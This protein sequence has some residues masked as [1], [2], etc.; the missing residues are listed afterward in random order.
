MQ[1]DTI[2]YPGA[3]YYLLYILQDKL[4]TSSCLQ[5]SF[6]KAIEQSVRCGQ[7]QAQAKPI[8][9]AQALQPFP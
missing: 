3:C 8:Q 6:S 2:P 9:A 1:A 4:D 5:R 7:G